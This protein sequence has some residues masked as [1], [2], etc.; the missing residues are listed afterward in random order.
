MPA[1]NFDSEQIQQILKVIG[2]GMQEK[3]YF[4]LPKDEKDKVVSALES[5]LKKLDEDDSEEPM[6][7]V[8]KCADAHFA[9][10][11][12]HYQGVLD[13]MLAKGSNKKVLGAAQNTF[14]W[15]ANTKEFVQCV[16]YSTFR[17]AQQ[18]DEKDAASTKNVVQRALKTLLNFEKVWK[19]QTAQLSAITA[20]NNLNNS[21]DYYIDDKGNVVTVPDALKSS[22]GNGA[23]KVALN[24]CET[25]TTAEQCEARLDPITKDT[26][27]CLWMPYSSHLAGPSNQTAKDKWDELLNDENPCRD[28]REIPFPLRPMDKVDEYAL[29]EGKQL[30]TT[31]YDPETKKM[32]HTMANASGPRRDMDKKTADFYSE[33]HGWTGSGPDAKIGV[34][35]TSALQPQGRRVPYFLNKQGDSVFTDKVG[36]ED[37]GATALQRLFRRFKSKTAEL[38]N[39]VRAEINRMADE[40]NSA[41]KSAMV[42]QTAEAIAILKRRSSQYPDLYTWEEKAIDDPKFV[43]YAERTARA[44]YELARKNKLDKADVRAIVRHDLE[45][46]KRAIVATTKKEKCDAIYKG[47]GLNIATNAGNMDVSQRSNAAILPLAYGDN[48]KASKDLKGRAGGFLSEEDKGQTIENV[49]TKQIPY[50][51]VEGTE[52]NNIAGNKSNEEYF[53]AYQPEQLNQDNM[54]VVLRGGGDPDTYLQQL[55]GGATD[56]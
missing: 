50:M 55:R 49:N 11:P 27:G 22:D 46:G 14:A 53:A 51:V 40:W 35:T 41:M 34:P 44:V 16:P 28:V 42:G 48:V 36:D 3:N 23:I 31:N 37:K 8:Q 32:A 12:T 2:G 17:L 6:M 56:S 15:D 54:F 10:L 20:P 13:K 25:A 7:V 45:S 18:L 52:L 9:P 24:K 39:N 43:T 47:L 21:A 30:D 4:D 26:G 33:K 38:P 29:A 1:K 19:K 5:L